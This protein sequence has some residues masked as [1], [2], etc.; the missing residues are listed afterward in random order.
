M[1][2]VSKLHAIKEVDLRD[3]HRSLQQEIDLVIRISQMTLAD[4][5]PDKPRGTKEGHVRT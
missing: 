2:R 1:V 3:S 5:R 4:E